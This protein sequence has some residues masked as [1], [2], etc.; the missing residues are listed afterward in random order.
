M[1]LCRKT[2]IEVIA[3]HRRAKV[4][5]GFAQERKRLC[6]ASVFRNITLSMFLVLSIDVPEYVT[7]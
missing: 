5:F 7:K 6:F 1:Q 2:I 4:I 3:R